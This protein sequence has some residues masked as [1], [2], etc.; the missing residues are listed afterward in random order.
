MDAKFEDLKNR[1]IEVDDLRSAAAL[2][3]WDQTTYMPS[4]GAE[5]RG[6]QMA[7]LGRIAQEKFTD[8]TIGK[9]LDDLSSVTESL[10]YDSDEASLIRVVKRDYER[11][12][13][14][15]PALLSE[16][17]THSTLS[18]QTWVQA[19]EAD[20]F[21]RM[22][23]FLEKSLDLSRQFADC[24]PG[25]NHIADPLIENA[26][27][28]MR[29]ATI[30]PL[31]AALRDQLVPLVQA[32]QAS[33]PVGDSCLYQDFPGLAQVDFGLAAIKR[34]GYDFER[35]RSDMTHHPYMT[36]FSLGDVRI[37]TRY[38]DEHL[39]DGIFATMHESG[40]AMYEQG[41]SLRY[42]GLPLAS[43]TS[44]GVHES[45]SR[46]WEN[47]IGRSRLYWQGQ[48]KNLQAIFP[49]QLNRVSLE[50]FYR[51]I[52]KVEPTLIRVKADEVTYNL[53][54]MLRFDLEV[55]LLEGGVA[56]KD[57][58]A[59]WNDR[60]Q[61]DLGLTPHNFSDGVLQD[62]HWTF[63]IGGMFQGYTLGNILSAQYYDAALKANPSIPAEIE[64]GQFKTLHRWLQDNIYQHGRKYTATEL[65]RKVTGHDLSLEPYM[66]YLK[67]KFGEIYGLD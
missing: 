56:I 5:A 4:G 29:V 66:H 45:Q 52:N 61:S 57:L 15:P 53:H 55:A 67:D 35:G 30:K 62:V 65:T 49:D 23:P 40:H 48:Y 2:L 47:L 28:G 58:P 24:F 60:Y 20:D 50:Q 37:T 21:S 43:G 26:D 22:I 34:F 12:V 64:R 7:T 10:A 33:T 51:A 25:Y 32:I 11:A 1:L 14:V 13:N 36:K 6:R 19:R 8:P 18:Y 27:S 38:D 17:T 44:S 31:F 46:L 63:G 41:V 54:I 16:M 39:G 59:A 42:E 3:S 9:L